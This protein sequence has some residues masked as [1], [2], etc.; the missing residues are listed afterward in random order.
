MAGSGEAEGLTARRMA[1][2][3]SELAQAAARMF[4]EQG[5][6]ATTVEGICARVDVS[7]RTFFRYFSSKDDVLDELVESHLDAFVAALSERPASEPVL[8]SLVAAATSGYEPSPGEV[9]F[10]E[11]FAVVHRTPA[12]RARWLDRAHDIQAR[13][14]EVLLPRLGPDDPGRA[15]LAAGALVGTMTT[16]VESWAEAPDTG[17]LR[18][19]VVGALVLLAGGFGLADPPGVAG[20]GS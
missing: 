14:G 20:G 19:L 4:K 9:D 6:E 1:R 16:V 17:D 10:P 13:L 15:R 18:E 5:F 2:T 12:L 3:R 7:P 8:A 11:L